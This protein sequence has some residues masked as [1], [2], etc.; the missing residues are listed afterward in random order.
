MLCSWTNFFGKVIHCAMKLEIMDK[1]YEDM[2]IL[3][4]KSKVSDKILR[5]FL[6]SSIKSEVSDK[7]LRLSLNLSIKRDVSDKLRRIS[8][9]LSMKT[10]ISDRFQGVSLNFVHYGSSKENLP[11]IIPSITLLGTTNQ[12]KSPFSRLC[13]KNRQLSNLF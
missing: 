2:R 10:N 11:A 1:I 4:I 13:R 6:N 7:I 3:S 9:I 8:Q 5:I 12:L